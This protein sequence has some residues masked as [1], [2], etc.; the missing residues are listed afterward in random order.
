[1]VRAI[2]AI[3]TPREEKVTKTA[4][5][6]LADLLAKRKVPFEVIM[7]AVGTLVQEVGKEEARVLWE[8]L[9]GPKGYTRKQLE[10]VAVLIENGVEPASDPSREQTKV[11]RVFPEE[12]TDKQSPRV[13]VDWDSLREGE[14]QEKRRQEFLKKL[15]EA[16]H[17]AMRQ[18]YEHYATSAI[19]QDFLGG[20]WKV[21][22]RGR[23][24]EISR[25][26]AYLA[27]R[28]LETLEP[29]L[30]AKIR[31]DD[32]RLPWQKINEDWT[33]KEAFKRG[34]PAKAMAKIPVDLGILNEGRG[35]LEQDLGAAIEVIRLSSHRAPA[36]EEVEE[37]QILGE[38]PAKDFEIPMEEPA[39]V[40]PARMSGAV[41]VK[42]PPT[43]PDEDLEFPYIEELEIESA[44]T[45]ANNPE[46]VRLL[47]EL[48]AVNA[49]VAVLEPAVQTLTRQVEALG[50]LKDAAH[51]SAL[52]AGLSLD[53]AYWTRL[54]MADE[55]ELRQL[56]EIKRVELSTLEQ[57]RD[58]LKEE[59]GQLKS[60]AVELT[61]AQADSA[62][63][64]L[65]GD[66]GEAI[67]KSEGYAPRSAK[68]NRH[69]AAASLP[70]AGLPNWV[71]RLKEAPQ[72]LREAASRG[73][74]GAESRVVSLARFAKEHP[75]DAKRLGLEVL[76]QAALTAST[77][78]GVK[79]FYTLPRYA[80]EKKRVFETKSALNSS[81]H[82]IMDAAWQ[83]KHGEIGG[84]EVAKKTRIYNQKLKTANLS[85]EERQAFRSKLTTVLRESAK[86]NFEIR[87][88]Q[89]TKID[90]AFDQYLKTKISSVEAVRDVVNWACTLSGLKAL[91][92]AAYGGLAVAERAQK[93]L[94]KNRV[95]GKTNETFLRDLVVGRARETVGVLRGKGSVVQKGVELAK[96]A[97]ILAR[98]YGLTK[99]GFSEGGQLTHEMDQLIHQFRGL[100]ERLTDH[101]PPL[102][103]GGGTVSG[104][105]VG[106]SESVISEPAPEITSASEPTTE[107][108]FEMAS[109]PAPGVLPL[110]G[111]P[112][113]SEEAGELFE[114]EDAVEA[115]NP[116]TPHTYG[117]VL[118]HVLETGSG[119][120][121]GVQAGEGITG[122]FIRQIAAH[123]EKFGLAENPTPGQVVRKAVSLAKKFGYMNEGGKTLWGTQAGAH[124]ELIDENHYRA[125]GGIREFPMD[126][127]MSG[128]ISPGQR[129]S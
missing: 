122:P 115:W 81:L 58:R 85:P 71:Q 107:P 103:E 23:R 36:T 106:H 88:S 91:R 31:W 73:L 61:P 53:E 26:S 7:R 15:P 111:E 13:A 44:P 6:K 104:E 69:E 27:K 30:L 119:D 28:D 25:L 98:A 89:H 32:I 74:E 79:A 1:M 8:R 50:G 38:T 10:R 86:Q 33:F 84:E 60:Q 3:E 124:Y 29:E 70:E 40:G 45:P 51:T 49:Q 21:T 56:L 54:R 67:E 65:S 57:K 2:A 5:E 105:M 96:A 18:M 80:I 109:E 120:P 101:V 64:V 100:G 68:P 78:L 90:E 34:Y 16:M 102:F 114:K 99:I 41:E 4:A 92:A 128:K 93:I 9:A 24:K 66:W 95:E 87:R 125:V 127:S 47:A 123:P 19:V 110:S 62:E 55:E 121:A 46:R 82:E 108:V 22:P 76:K 48:S 12:A 37:E 117:E 35:I 63:D 17:R 97:G 59:I 42:P 129:D 20:L 75:E 113:E 83:R 116:N 43:P 14:A 39:V 94:R 52:E 72:R 126:S 11:F 77:Y 118:D 112:S